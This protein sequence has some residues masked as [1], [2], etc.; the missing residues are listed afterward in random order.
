MLLDLTPGHS[1]NEQHDVYGTK[2]LKI[3]TTSISSSTSATGWMQC[4]D[5]QIFYTCRGC[6]D[7]TTRIELNSAGVP[8]VQCSGCKGPGGKTVMMR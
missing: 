3:D 2:N 7:I 4:S 1:G 6:T 8:N 5:G